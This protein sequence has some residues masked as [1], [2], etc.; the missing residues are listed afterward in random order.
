MMRSH[1]EFP[2]QSVNMDLTM[3]YSCY[4]SDTMASHE[5]RQEVEWV[6]TSS[7]SVLRVL[8]LPSLQNDLFFISSNLDTELHYVYLMN[9]LI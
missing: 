9:Q 1:S 6:C 8:K 5:H 4:P 7:L 2:W 3:C